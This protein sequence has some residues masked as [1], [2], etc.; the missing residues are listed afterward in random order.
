MPS[1]TKVED[2]GHALCIEQFDLKSVVFKLSESFRVCCKGLYIFWSL[3]LFYLLVMMGL[4][5][6][7]NLD[8]VALA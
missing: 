2:T 4:A 1:S 8:D 6:V 7:F 5:F 3:V